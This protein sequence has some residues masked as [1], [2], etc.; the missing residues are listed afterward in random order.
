MKKLNLKE[1][2]L[3][4][5]ATAFAV[6]TLTSC[7]ND[8]EVLNQVEQ[9]RGVTAP[10]RVQVNDFA[11]SVGDI[12]N[13]QTRTTMDPAEYKNVGAITLAFY[14]AD[15]TEMYA[16]TQL[17][18]GDTHYTTFGTFSCNL[19]VGSYTMLVIARDSLADD[20]FKLN[21]L[22]EAGF[23]SEKVRET[24]CKTQNVSV[25][26]STPLDLSI[27]LNR[28]VPQLSICSTDP[29]PTGVGKIRTTYSAGYKSFNPTTGLGIGNAGFSLINT[30][31][32]AVGKVVEFRNN[33]YLATDEQTMTITLDVLD[34]ED[35]VLISKVI[36]NVP[37]KRNRRTVLRGPLFTPSASTASFQLEI[38]WLDDVTVNF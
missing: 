21:S 17:K 20:V 37:L 15:G 31:S 8:E 10:V 26:S 3:M 12:P 35:H 13:A 30:P 11:M 14:A 33:T 36:P 4:V 24:F 25:T 29:R 6:V 1:A 28:I 32:A 7:N 16:D 27:T 38:S 9:S 22:T 2:A 5:G 18:E 23:T 34:A 19:P